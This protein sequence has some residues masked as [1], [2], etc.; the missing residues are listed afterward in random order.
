M[1]SN[2]YRNGL[3]NQRSS[4]RGNRRSLL[5][6]TLGVIG[7]V[8]VIGVKGFGSIFPKK[9]TEQKLLYH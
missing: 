1:N 2:Q 6:R 7:T 4:R 9:T 8:V 3:S 5:T